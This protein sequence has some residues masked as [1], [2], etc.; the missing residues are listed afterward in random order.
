MQPGDGGPA[1]GCG[2]DPAGGCDALLP[3]SPGIRGAALDSKVRRRACKVCGILTVVPARQGGA[4]ADGVAGV[5]VA[6]TS[7]CGCPDQGTSTVLNRS[8]R[9]IG[10]IF[11]VKTRTFPVGIPR[12]QTSAGPSRS[13]FQRPRSGTGHLPT[14]NLQAPTRDAAFPTGSTLAPDL[15]THFP[16]QPRSTRVG[17]LRFPVLPRRYPT[18]SRKDRTVKPVFQPLELRARPL[19]PCAFVLTAADPT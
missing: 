13:R 8:R 18:R 9:W 6:T 14:W 16:L 15:A 5:A 10:A 4:V 3:A 2:R 12:V 11:R 7:R 17:E 19:N 1:A